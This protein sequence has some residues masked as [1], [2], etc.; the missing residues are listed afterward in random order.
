MGRLLHAHGGMKSYSNAVFCLVVSLFLGA[1]A[2]ESWAKENLSTEFLIEGSRIPS[3]LKDKFS[4]NNFGPDLNLQKLLSDMKPIAIKP[5]VDLL[6]LNTLG[7]ATARWECHDHQCQISVNPILWEKFPE[8]KSVLALHEYLGSLGYYDD[9]YW[10]STSMWFLSLDATQKALSATMKSKIERWIGKNASL[11]FPA[12]TR[13]A[14][15]VVGAGGGGESASLWA[16]MF[17]LKNALKVLQ[18]PD[19]SESD[20]LAALRTIEAKL[21]SELAVMW[22]PNK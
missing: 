17:S 2:D 3:R 20:K 14:G 19:S 1:P 12:N 21:S 16:R 9:N 10:I 8:Q 6:S 18:S 7:R 4:Y 13:V 11:R 22:S 5:S 15:G